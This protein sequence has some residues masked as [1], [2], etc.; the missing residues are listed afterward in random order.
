MREKFGD[1]IVSEL[2]REKNT[3]NL[4]W[5]A[6]Y[7]GPYELAFSDRSDG[8]NPTTRQLWWLVG[9]KWRPSS[10]LH[11]L[12]QKIGHKQHGDSLTEHWKDRYYGDG[13]VG[14]QI[15]EGHRRR[16]FPGYEVGF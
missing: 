2:T 16:L 13:L 11:E 15:F 8:H 1:G 5:G 7:T 4:A 12:F 3:S 9:N 14:W 10:R 6:A